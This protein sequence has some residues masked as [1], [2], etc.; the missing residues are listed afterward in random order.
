MKK[1]CILFL[2]SILFLTACS[3]DSD[4]SDQA[5]GAKGKD[6]IIVWAWDPNF[7]IKAME[8]AKQVYAS[9]NA[10]VTIDIIE[11]AQDDIV[12]KLNTSLSSGTTKG[13]P[14]IVL[15]EDYR[16]QSF[17]QAY[18]DAFHKITGS[19]NVDDFAPYKMSPTSL[20]GENYGLPFDTGVAGLY[21]RTDYLEESGYTI[22]DL[23]N[24]DW[25]KYIEIGKEIKK[26]TGK[27]L[28][29]LDPNDLG[30]IR[31]MIQSAGSWYT[32]D[33]G[34][35]PDIAGNE[36]LKKAFQVY[37]QL[38]DADIAKPVSDWSQFLAAFNNGDVASVPTGNWI[39]PSVK[40]EASQSE[41]WAVLPF[42]KLPDIESSVNA[43]NLG[44]SSWYVLDVA[45]KE[46]A[47]DF[48]VATFGSNE[49]F[50]QDLVTEIGA[51]GTYA[52]A[53]E[54]EAYKAEDNYF[55][56]QK[57]IADFS[58]WTKQIPQ[59]N[60]GMHTYAIEDIIVVAMQ[61]YLNGKELDKVLE[62]AQKEAEA[63]LQ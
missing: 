18:P 52:P 42:P 33:D 22:D 38:L 17:L 43:T 31:M 3:S 63:Q 49:D 44:G 6:E 4:E 12:Q 39:T 32:K 26:V 34:V 11:N 8:L 5:G 55:N 10:D 25:N 51:I 27:Q 50:Y 2:F 53:I 40:A 24:A 1:V 62:D 23:N 59:V 60:Y 57:I 14:N 35:T 20:E 45:G 36:A 47:V 54:G 28:L 13:L 37:K 7:N 30:Q 48:L 58:N 56:G 61:D 15:I 21:V 16:A 19:F 29:T 46:K 9:E 41:N